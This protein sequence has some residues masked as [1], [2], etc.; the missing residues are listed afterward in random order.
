MS[1]KDWDPMRGTDW[2][3]LLS[4]EFGKPYWAK[5]QDF[6]EEE[7]SHYDVYP[8]HDEVFAALRLTPS[9]KTKVVIVGQDPYA[10]AGQANGL[11]FSVPRGVRVPPSLANI[12]KE[13][14]DDVGELIPDH[15]SLEPWA[16]Q[17]VLLLNA[18][19]TVRERASGSHRGMG[20]EKFTDAVIRHVAESDPVF[21]LWGK[22]AQNKTEAL[23]KG[24]GHAVIASPHPSPLA[25]RKGFFGSKPFSQAN[26]ALVDAGRTAIDWK[27]TN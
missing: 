19:L 16:R 20:W 26:Q 4:Q 7:R 23:I 9:A 17:G 13:L 2:H 5:L 3:R 11:A 18:T 14:H 22:S 24:S 8:P 12:H 25:A 6:L 10:R 1:E 21:I 15:G 27:L